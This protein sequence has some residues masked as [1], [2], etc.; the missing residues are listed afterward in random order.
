ME[1]LNEFEFQV[2]EQYENEKGVFTVVSMD[3]E[4]MVIRWADGEEIRT[5]IDLQRRIHSRRKWEKEKIEAKANTAKRNASKGSGAARKEFIGLEQTDFKDTVAQ[6]TWRGRDQLGGAVAS[7]ITANNLNINSWAFAKKPELHWLDTAHRKRGV[8]KYLSRLFARV[9]HA[10]LKFGFYAVRPDDTEGTSKDWETLLEWLKDEKNDHILH[11]L[12]SEYELTT[13]LRT[14]S[15]LTELEALEEGWHIKSGIKEQTVDTLTA[16]I[17]AMPANCQIELEL[18]R[19]IEN[20]AAVSRGT[21]IADDIAELI[22]VLIP[23]YRVVSS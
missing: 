13:H 7:K 16:C 14:P 17:D 19:T 3:R 2:D 4:N 9:D 11:S 6:T 15:T 12:A 23:V 1:S 20:A 10:S 8:A 18:A 21:N 22:M 5:D